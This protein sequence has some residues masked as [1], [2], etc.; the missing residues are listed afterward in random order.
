MRKAFSMIM[1]IFII[2]LMSTVAVFILN[3]SAKTVKAT[4]YQY[5]HEQAILLARSYTELAIMY[6]S[7]N[8]SNVTNCAEDISGTF[9]PIG[10]GFDIKVKIAYIGPL[11][12]SRNIIG[13]CN[14]DRI[15][16]ATDI[17]TPNEL[18]IIVDTFVSYPDIDHPNDLNLTYHRRTLQK[19]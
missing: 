12:G 6:A 1:A 2:V 14:T 11:S 17:V 7:A 3:V 8:E 18:Q 10:E 9:G 4:V 13:V 16:N 5:R 15:L 19:L